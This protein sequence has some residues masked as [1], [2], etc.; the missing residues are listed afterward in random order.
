M[1]GAA[2]LISFGTPFSNP[3]LVR[4]FTVGAP[5][6]ATDAATLYAGAERGYIDYPTMR[7][8]AHEGSHS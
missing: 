3:D 2:D 4:R 8:E 1:S 7:F 6:A 5:L